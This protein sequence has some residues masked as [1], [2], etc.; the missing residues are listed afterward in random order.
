MVLSNLLDNADEYTDESGH[1]WTAAQQ[2]EHSMEITVTNTGCRLT[3][4]QVTRVFDCFW[5]GDS[6]RQGTGTHCGLGLAL[7]QRL[8]RALGGSAVA[9]LQPKGIFTVQ[10][11]F[12]VRR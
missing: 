12:P 9:E 2:T 6:S 1:I 8:V 10:L 11:T 3:A 4:D 7:V 5:R